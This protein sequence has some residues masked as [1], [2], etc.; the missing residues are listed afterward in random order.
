MKKTC[1]HLNSV[2]CSYVILTVMQM[3]R[4]LQSAEKAQ[5]F[6]CT[7]A[8]TNGDCSF[9]WPAAMQKQESSTPI[10]GCCN[11]DFQPFRFYS[12]QKKQKYKCKKY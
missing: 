8:N 3:L 10:W 6:P 4:L 11:M 5:M 2:F 7:A 9:S 12:L 1:V